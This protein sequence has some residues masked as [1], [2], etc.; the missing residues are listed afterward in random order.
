MTIREDYTA[1]YNAIV[2]TTKGAAPHNQIMIG[3][4]LFTLFE[5]IESWA[6][7]RPPVGR[8]LGHDEASH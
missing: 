2:Q 7:N 5:R 1:N 6:T 3:A 4:I 8:A